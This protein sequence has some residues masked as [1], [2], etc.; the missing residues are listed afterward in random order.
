MKMKQIA[1]AAVFALSASAFAQSSVTLYGIVDTGIE[2]VSHANVKGD[3]VIRMPGIT[4]EVPSRWG[5]R[6][7][8]DLGGGYKAVFTLESGF[9]V[10]GGDLGQGGRLFG[11][12][13]WVGVSGPYG[14]LSF[15]R[16]YTMT[17]WA[18]TDSDIIGPDIY[19]LGS[20]DAY[21]PNARSDNTIAYKGTFSGLTIGATYSFG[22][23][24]AGTGN[25]PGQGTCAGQI[26]G[27]PTNCRQWSAMLKYDSTNFGLA[28]AYDEQRGGATAAA[29]FFNGVAPVALTNGADKDVRIQLDGWASLYGVKIG[30]GWL[31]RR[32]ATDSPAV[33]NVNSDLF[34]LGASY[35]ITPAIIIDGEGYRIVNAKQNA[36][37][38]MGTLRGTYLLSKRTSVYLQG[39]Y[40]GNSAHAAYSVSSGGGGT[41]PAP[42]NDQVGIMAGI[43]HMF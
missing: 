17:F 11:R 1:A 4:G 5:M 36:R 39:S 7:A 6:G 2:Y 32:V 15:G 35:V 10:R 16:Q 26:A 22:R 3:S 41:T 8:E 21:I 40:L 33:P 29:N 25:S 27:S 31:G 19:G 28:A 23:D 9:N 13:A 18:N 12:Q 20:L 43:R 30:G 34:Y 38:T 37:A 24:S 14:Q 42:G